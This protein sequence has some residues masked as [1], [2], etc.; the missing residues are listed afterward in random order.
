M[1]KMILHGTIDSLI[2]GSQT[3]N[4]SMKITVKNY[5]KNGLGTNNS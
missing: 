1:W 4:G 2:K 3:I 5:F